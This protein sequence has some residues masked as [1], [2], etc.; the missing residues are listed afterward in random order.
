MRLVKFTFAPAAWL[1]LSQLHTL[2]DVDLDVASAAAIAAA[3]P[4]LHTLGIAVHYASSSSTAAAVAGFFDTLLP[5]LRSFRFYILF[6]ACAWPVDDTTTTAPAPLPQLQDAQ[7]V[8]LR[9]PYQVIAKYVATRRPLSRV[10]DLRFYGTPQPADAASVL[11]AAPVVR[12]RVMWH[13]D[14]AFA[15]F[16]HRKLRSLRFRACF[17]ER[18]GCGAAG[19]AGVESCHLEIPEIAA[20]RSEPLPGV[21]GLLPP[22]FVC[23]IIPGVDALKLSNPL[24]VS[25]LRPWRS[26]SRQSRVTPLRT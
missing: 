8:L 6:G 22:P 10:R 26:A 25:F 15:G 20:Y 23:V 21:T 9:A 12:D 3:L 24:A 2:L 7:P 17:E 19:R 13:N 18:S 11:R 4:R 1:G 5:R 16:M 14:P